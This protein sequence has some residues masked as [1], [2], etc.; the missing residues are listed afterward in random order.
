LSYG[1]IYDY[2]GNKE[3]IFVLVHDF[4]TGEADKWLD[5]I[6]ESITDPIEKL[7]GMIHNEFE[8]SSRWSDAI[9]FVY[10]D[11]HILKKEVL[12][13]LLS[14][15]TDHVRRFKKVLD[16]CVEKGYIRNCNTHIIAN[17]VKVMVDS[18]VIKRWDL[19]GITQFEMEN[20][21]LS[22]FFNGLRVD[23]P[24]GKRAG[25]TASEFDGK[26]I[27]II[28]GGSIFGSAISSFLVSCG[29]S[30]AIY[31][32]CDDMADRFMR[33]LP[34]GVEKNGAIK[35][36]SMEE[37][38]P[39]NS[40]L[41]LKVQREC[42]PIEIVVQDIGVRESNIGNIEK[43]KDVITNQLVE[44][45]NM[46]RT[47]SNALKSEFAR[48]RAGKI[49]YIAPWAWDK[50][51]DSVLYETIKASTIALSS[52]NAER[53]R[54][55]GVSVNCLVPGHI[56]GIR[57]L[58]LLDEQTSRSVVEPILKKGGLGGVSDIVKTA[59]FLISDSTKYLTGQ[60]ITVDGGIH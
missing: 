59:A 58:T 4:L 39:M 40:Q 10:Q 16:D 2:V 45:I 8:L 25:E 7:K 24:A 38:G 37:Y 32:P 5:K 14:K 50:Y 1:N 53:M 46:A 49:L 54:E 23:K 57:D 9:L 11:I 31:E 41:I 36:Y 47:I 43:K 60:V 20:A 26:S 56:G 19:R 27:L 30:L 48:M 17:L 29:A 28:N 22:L 52:A 12:K 21:I 44:N 51:V 35:V 6:M 13:K 34:C 3:D 15:E 18:W 33:S 42:G 55:F